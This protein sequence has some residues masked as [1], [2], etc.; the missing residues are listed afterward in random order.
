M[1]LFDGL[2]GEG[3]PLVDLIGRT[4]THWRNGSPRPEG[5]NRCAPGTASARACAAG[6]VSLNTIPVRE[7]PQTTRP[8]RFRQGMP[9]ILDAR[10]CGCHDVNASTMSS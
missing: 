9:K 7:K 4:T 6:S 10:T 1:I 5:S 2:V 8:P 3:L